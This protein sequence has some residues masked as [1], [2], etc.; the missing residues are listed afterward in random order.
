MNAKEDQS[1]ADVPKFTNKLLEIVV[2]A[3]VRLTSRPG[4][5]VYG[6]ARVCAVS[7]PSCRVSLTGMI[8]ALQN[9]TALRLGNEDQVLFISLLFGC[10]KGELL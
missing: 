3:M 9:A 7:V 10:W 2:V 4:A 6:S 1:S 5:G 8:D